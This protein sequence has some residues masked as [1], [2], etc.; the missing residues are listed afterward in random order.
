MFEIWVAKQQ[1]THTHT[2]TCV[3]SEVSTE[4]VL[5]ANKKQTSYKADQYSTDGQRDCESAL[6]IVIVAVACRKHVLFTL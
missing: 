2:H 1:T 6:H 5:S 3:D 4:D